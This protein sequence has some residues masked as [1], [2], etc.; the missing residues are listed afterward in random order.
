MPMTPDAP[1][2]GL[3]GGHVYLLPFRQPIIDQA[4]HLRLAHWSGNEALKGS[5]L[6][7][8][9]L[10][11]SSSFTAAEATA[12]LMT[13]SRSSSMHVLHVRSPDAVG[14]HT[15]DGHRQQDLMN[16]SISTS[17]FAGSEKWDHT[18]GVMVTGKLHAPKG[19]AADTNAVIGFSLESQASSSSGGGG[20][21]VTTSMLMEVKPDGDESR[22]T[23]V[24]D[25]MPCENLAGEWDSGGH[26]VVVTQHGCVVTALNADGNF[27]WWHD[28]TGNVSAVSKSQKV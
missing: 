28:P 13:G 22:S 6:P 11:T 25:S 12:H 4:E 2:G 7:P 19:D 18:V 23:H 16:A 27:T 20:G 24:Y 1:R 14:N 10:S 21:S 3:S 8:P 9:T 26:L 5:P 15:D 17:W